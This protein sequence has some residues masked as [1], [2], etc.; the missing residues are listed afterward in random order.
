[1]PNN[2]GYRCLWAWLSLAGC[3]ALEKLPP[4]GTGAPD[5]ERS[6]DSPDSPDSPAPVRAAGIVLILTDDQRYDTLWAMPN[7][8]ELLVTQGVEF[9]Q[10]VVP[11]AVCCPSRASLLS[12]GFRA[13]DTG[14]LDNYGPQGGVDVVPDADTVAVRLQALGWRTGLIGKYMN[15]YAEIA[16][17]TP[18]GWDLFLVPEGYGGDWSSATWNRGSSTPAASSAGTQTEIVQ[19]LTDYERDAALDFLSGVGDAPFLLILSVPAPH[20]PAQYPAQDAALFSDYTWDAGTSTGAWNEADTSDKPA[21]IQRLPLINAN[22]IATMQASIRDQLRSLQPVDRLVAA[23]VERLESLD[24]MDTTLIAFTS[25]NGYTWGEHRLIEK[26]LVPYDES[27][28]VPLVIRAPGIAP[29]ASEALVTGNLDLA[30]TILDLA[31]LPAA[32]GTMSLWPLL[33]DPARPGHNSLP[34]EMYSNALPAYTGVLTPEWKYISYETGEVELYDRQADPAELDNLAADPPAAAPI[35]SFEQRT[36]EERGV[37]LPPQI[38]PD[39]TI[40][41]PCAY[42]IRGWYG[43]APQTWTLED[44][45]LPPGLSL[46]PGGRIVGTPTR[47]GTFAFTVRLTDASVS[48]WHGGPRTHAVEMHLT[49]LAADAR[50][51]QPQIQA[52]RAGDQ[53]LIRVAAPSPVHVRACVSLTPDFEAPAAC[54]AFTGPGDGEIRLPATWMQSWRAIIDGE[55][56][57]ACPLPT[58]E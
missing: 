52:A 41:A 29:G 17:Y 34:L 23:V 10:A 3:H 51:A 5:S 56:G 24:L 27:I 1:M 53:L 32:P 12:G 46:A 38:P 7:V 57:P 42:T 33:L 39:A 28:R 22:A 13:P 36:L 9:R 25:D 15:E 58:S 49:V 21:Y 55:W 11:G 6:P 2:S 40:G 54:A 31:G 48:P 18:P 20:Y 8:Q 16:P 35:V 26:K 14:V 47:V 50:R 19:Y 4:D 43:A 30:A 37:Y 45:A 44:G